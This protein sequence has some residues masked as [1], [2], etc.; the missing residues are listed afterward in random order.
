MDKKIAT[1][2]KSQGFV[3]E[4]AHDH[5]GDAL[6]YIKCEEKY[7]LPGLF[8]IHTHGAMQRC[9]ND[10]GGAAFIMMDE[11][12]RRNGIWSYL[13]TVITD[14]KEQLLKICENYAQIAKE[15]W[16]CCG[17][18]YL[19]GPFI[20]PVKKGAHNEKYIVDPDFTF[21]KQLYE[22]SGGTIK[23][24]TVAPEMLGAIEF[25]QA[26]SK[27]CR[28]AIGHTTADYETA[29]T[30][31]RAGATSVTHLFNAMNPI[32]H[33]DPGV[34]GAA[35]DVGAY[36]ELI[37]DGVHIHPSVIRMVFN[38]FSKDRIILISDS[39]SATGLMDGEYELGGLKTI[40]RNGESRLPDG[41]LAG[42][43]TNLKRCIEKAVEFGIDI[44]DAVRA[45]YDNPKEFLDGNLGKR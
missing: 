14:S 34:V 26:A 29:M 31:F 36:V 22:A 44:E 43:T 35:R 45:A 40:V 21:F 19:E 25:I 15:E 5:Q 39:I 6:K 3:L 32:L 17:G 9:A 13:P 24:V 7:I 37:S 18:L 27:L 38:T 33:R 23:V 42:S 10:L 20:N 2:S 11:H 30:A 4:G 1:Y 12:M 16:H 28:V 41:T 8:D